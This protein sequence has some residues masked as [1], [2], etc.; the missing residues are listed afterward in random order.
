MRV[1]SIEIGHAEYGFRAHLH[2]SVSTQN[3]VDGIYLD[4]TPFSDS[5]SGSETF[6]WG[7]GVKEMLVLSCVSFVAMMDAF[8]ATMMTPIVPVLSAVFEHSFYSILWIDMSY[9]LA[10][11]ASQ[12]LFA[13]LSEVFGQ[14]PILIA[15]VVIAIVGTGVCSGSLSILSLVAGRLVQGAGSGGAMAVSLLLV[16]DLIPYTHRV[17]FSDHICRA[18]ALGAMLGPLTGGFFGEYGNWNWTFY[19]SYVFSTLSLFI[20]P[21]AINLRECTS[22]S[23]RAALEMDW[24]GAILTFLGLGPLLL[25][26]SWVGQR[27]SGWD[28]WRII[29]SSC[30]GGLAMVILV[31]YESVWVAQPMFNLGIFNSIHTIM[32]YAGSLLYGIL[33]LGHLQNLSMYIFLVKYFSSPLTGVSMLAVTGPAFLI[34][35]LLSKMHQGRY[36]FRTR[37]I[38]RA[39]WMLSLLATGCFI[40]LNPDTP[41]PGWVFIFFATGLSHVLL[42]FGYHAC[43]HTESLTRKRE[44]QAERQG[45]REGRGSSPAFAILMYSILRTWGMCIAVPVGGTIVL[46]QIAQEIDRSSAD[47]SSPLARQN[48]ILLSPDNREELGRLFLGGFRVVWRFFLGVSALGGISSLMIR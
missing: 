38:I 9:L 39:G 36:S 29:I 2:E 35:L 7:H 21:F 17:R 31:L 1:E 3:L 34:L 4:D 45:T 23:R 32:L 44:E 40:L 28:D 8:H 27:P 33:I 37:W 20:T 19:F 46:T 41:T 25:G 5:D 6:S 22:I 13:M 30:I 47:S 48:E 16:T 26:V 24:L 43:S 10:S 18:W 14:G 42:A 15:A 11:A 12:P